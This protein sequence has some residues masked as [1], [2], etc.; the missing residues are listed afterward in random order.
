MLIRRP[1]DIPSS[2]I[3]PES[4]Y[5]NRRQFMGTAGALAL[6][7]ALTPSA[8]QALA[9]TGGVQEDKVTPEEDATTYNNFY[10]FGT[11]KEDPAENAKGFKTTPWTVTVEGLVKNPNTAWDLNDLLAKLTL[12]D[13]TYRMRCVEG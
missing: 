4:V 1:D 7:T 3:T 13:R 10:E 8:L 6:G 9:A 5:Q 2:E 12:Y 11:G